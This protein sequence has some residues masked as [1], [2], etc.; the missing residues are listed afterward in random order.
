M[1]REQMKKDG[2]QGKP[3]DDRTIS[4]AL[5]A[6]ESERQLGTGAQPGSRNDALS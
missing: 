5:N 1:V 4:R 2:F 6:W 3:V